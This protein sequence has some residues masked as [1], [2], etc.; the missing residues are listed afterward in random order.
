MGKVHKQVLE[1]LVIT[2]ADDIKQERT[3]SLPLALSGG[4]TVAESILAGPL[5]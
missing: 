3:Y 4:D 2:I 5:N 1:G